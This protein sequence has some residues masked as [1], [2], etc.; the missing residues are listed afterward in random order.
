[1]PDLAANAVR[2]RRTS[3]WSNARGQMAPVDRTADS[4]EPSA[5][6]Y[7]PSRSPRLSG[8]PRKSQADVLCA[9]CVPAREESEI[10]RT[11]R[12]PGASP[13]ST[14]V[15]PNTHGTRWAPKGEALG[16]SAAEG[17][18]VLG[19]RQNPEPRGR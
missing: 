19:W 10:A 15:P 4:S 16:G 8:N 5:R 7:L 6:R 17:L 3:W 13:G 11:A 9:Y 1:M 14:R 12:F 18:D 2:D